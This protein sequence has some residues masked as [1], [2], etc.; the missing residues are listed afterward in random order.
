MSIKNYLSQNSKIKKMT[1]VRTFNWGIPAFR[2]K[3]NFNTCP[4]AGIC[5]KGCYAKQG[6][7]IW[8]NV[9]Q[10]F[11]NRL[12]LSKSNQFIDTINAELKRR[13]VERLRIH[14]SGDFY[15]VRYTSKWLDI[16]KNNPHI[17]FYAYTKMVTMFKIGCAD[18]L[19]TLPNLTIIYSYG[20]KEDDLI[21][22]SVD[23][24]SRVFD[25]L[26]ELLTAGYVDASKNDA[27]AL[28][29]NPKVGLIYH[30]AKSKKWTI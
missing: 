29:S 13:K 14:D 2:S 19:S 22:P 15:N 27:N 25:N 6:T 12:I 20:G 21:D 3:D 5:A 9:S 10:A 16:I 18:I 7:Y 30:G 1:G 24:H 23:R 28:T 11:E 4:S 17:Q 8:S 26:E